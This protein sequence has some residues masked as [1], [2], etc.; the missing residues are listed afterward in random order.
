MEVEVAQTW[1][2]KLS[3]ASAN[4][5]TLVAEVLNVCVTASPGCTV[6]LTSSA[7]RRT[8]VASGGSGSGSEHRRARKLSSEVDVEVKRPV[9]GNMSTTTALPLPAS[10]TANSSSL[11]AVTARLI[12]VQPGGAAEANT[13]LGGSL[14]VDQ[15]VR[16]VAAELG[17]ANS[18]LSVD[19]Q[20]PIFPPMPPPSLPPL[21]STPPMLPPTSP[22]PTSPPP[23]SPPP[24]LPPPVSPPPTIPPPLLPLPSPPL[25]SPAL[26]PPS[27]PQLEDGMGFIVI[28]AA[29]VCGGAVLLALVAAITYYKRSSIRKLSTSQQ[30]SQVMITLPPQAQQVGSTSQII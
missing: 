3:S 10:V 17:L 12:V 6:S 21:P 5:T 25:S 27:S 23:T 19:V 20:Q 9:T 16:T 1:S 11:E 26:P 22:P 29:A 15:V 8:L 7:S 18:T 4:A 2:L 13:L 30:G 14:A 24:A 28:A